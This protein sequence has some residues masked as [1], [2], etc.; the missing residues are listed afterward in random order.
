MATGQLFLSAISNEFR[1]YREF[2]DRAMEHP[3]VALRE[4]S[5]FVVSG[6][7]TLEKLDDHIRQCDG[8]IH[9]P[10]PCGPCRDATPLWRNACPRAAPSWSQAHRCSATPS[11]TRQECGMALPAPMK[12]LLRILVGHESPVNTLAVLPEERLSSGSADRTLRVRD[13]VRGDTKSGQLLSMAN[14]SISALAFLPGLSLLVAG[15][16]SGRLHWL[17]LKGCRGPAHRPPP[18]RRT[19]HC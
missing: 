7:S 6:V 10:N 13:P 18:P 16:A 4:Q 2:L 8:V 17:R 9:Q 3:N 15:D 5:N 19:Q 12:A 11:E 14:A 1:S